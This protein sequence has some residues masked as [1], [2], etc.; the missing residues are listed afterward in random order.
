MKI[1]VALGGNALTLKNQKGTYKQLEE[2]I[3]KSC[4]VL[5][6]LI[7]K[8]DLVIVSGSGPQIGSLILKNEISKSKVP[9][10]PVDV[11]D[12][13]LEGELGYLI[14]KNLSN[15]LTKNNINKSV[16]TMLNQVIVNKNDKAF[17]NPTKPI[18]PF[19]T[20][21]QALRLRG[22][23]KIKEVIGGYRRVIASPIPLKVRNSSIIQKLMKNKVI[24][25][26]AGGGGIPVYKDKN[27]N[28]KG[29]EAVIDKDLSA[30]CL[31]KDIKADLLLILTN[32][33]KV[34]L[35][36]NKKDQKPLFKL[37][38]KQ[39]K[40]YLKEGQFPVGSMKPKIKAAINFLT[41]KK[42]KVI[43]TSPNYIKEALVGK[44]GTRIV[45]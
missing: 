3:K 39:A 41:D 45:R 23:Y 26:A 21:K 37:N 14:N 10:M 4:K 9:A 33:S 38:S 32:V 17:K 43:I 40:K 27:N 25:I 29:V 20:K 28:L 15:E 34:Y 24:V 1:V 35:N 19:Y 16:V 36:Y 2:N 12:A 7:K 30:A 5:I 22:K 6:P 42:R 31:A 44:N 8:H 11:L 18:G 13:E